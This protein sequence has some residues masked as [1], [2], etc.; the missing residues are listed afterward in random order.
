MD[1]GKDPF[2]ILCNRNKKI[3]NKKNKKTKKTKK[4]KK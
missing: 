3:K 1:L 2:R 4:I